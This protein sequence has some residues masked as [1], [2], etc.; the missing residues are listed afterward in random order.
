M[1]EPIVDVGIAAR[2][3]KQVLVM[4]KDLKM[5]AGKLAAQAAHASMAAVLSRG[6]LANGVLCIPMDAQIGPWLAGL[7]TKIVVGVESEAELI[8]LYESAKQAGLPCALIKDSGLTEFK[9]VP[10][11]TGVA[12]GPALK[13]DVDRITGHLP[14]NL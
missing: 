5:R 12:V 6:T 8:A 10:T 3:H 9:G 2:S 4:R 1:P 14:L 13:A 11:L 7:F